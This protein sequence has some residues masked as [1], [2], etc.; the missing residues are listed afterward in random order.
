M[1]TMVTTGA[2]LALALLGGGAGPAVA[3]DDTEEA[4][5]L[6]ESTDGKCDELKK[7]AA[8]ELGDSIVSGTRIETAVNGAI[9]KLEAAIDELKEKFDSDDK[10]R[11]TRDE[12]RAVR[13][14][15]KDVAAALAD[16]SRGSEIWEKWKPLQDEIEKLAEVYDLSGD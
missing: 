16:I 4:E 9:G 3:D 14:A 12:A 2:V 7:L 15:A 8:E 6:I 5:E 13:S 10:L 11:K 1:R